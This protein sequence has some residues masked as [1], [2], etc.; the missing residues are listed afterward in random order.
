MLSILY[1][2]QILKENKPNG[3]INLSN[4]R[5]DFLKKNRQGYIPGIFYVLF[6]SDTVIF[7]GFSF[8]KQDYSYMKE[9]LELILKYSNGNKTI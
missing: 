2:D 1:T 8:S 3:D 7:Y 5:Y 6:H 4:I 9:Y